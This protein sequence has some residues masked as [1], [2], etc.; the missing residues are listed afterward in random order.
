MGSETVSVVNAE[1][2]FV[3]PDITTVISYDILSDK[4]GCVNR[5]DVQYV[6]FPRS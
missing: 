3:N 1:E 2:N 6:S 5:R 4:V